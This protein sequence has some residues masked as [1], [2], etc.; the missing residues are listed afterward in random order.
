MFIIIY[1]DYRLFITLLKILIII[2]IEHI[3]YHML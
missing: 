3:Y 1:S 2:N